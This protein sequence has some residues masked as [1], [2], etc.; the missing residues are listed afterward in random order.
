MLWTLVVILLGIWVAGMVTGT[1][2][3]GVIYAFLLLALLALSIEMMTGR[4]AIR[5]YI[6]RRIGMDKDKLEGKLEDMKGRVKRQVGEWT[7]DE[8]LQAEGTVDQAKGKVQNTWGKVKEG[9]RE[10]KE[11]IKDAGRDVEHEDIERKERDDSAA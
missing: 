1:T 10:I 4:I 3:G 8:E 9:A 7:G 11:D 6:S 5:S 2:L